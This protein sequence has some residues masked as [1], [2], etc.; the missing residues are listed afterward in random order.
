MLPRRRNSDD[1]SE[2]RHDAD[3]DDV[4][5]TTTID[6]DDDVIVIF[7]AVV[8]PASIVDVL[9]SSRDAER[10]PSAT[11]RRMLGVQ[12]RGREKKRTRRFDEREIKSSNALSLQAN[13]KK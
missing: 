8:A 10:S 9:A 12:T 7:A 6:D 2:R 3:D 4:A 1:E 5:P 13:K 11:K